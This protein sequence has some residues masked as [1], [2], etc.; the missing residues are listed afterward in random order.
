V[1]APHRLYQ[2]SGASVSLPHR[3]HAAC[4]LGKTAP[5]QRPVL[6][7]GRSDR[8]SHQ[9]VLDL[10]DRLGGVEALGTHIDTV[11]DRVVGTTPRC[12]RMSGFCKRGRPV[13]VDSGLMLISIADACRNVCL[14]EALSAAVGQNRTSADTTVIPPIEVLSTAP[15]SLL[16][17]DLH[18]DIFPPSSRIRGHSHAAAWRVRS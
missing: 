18:T 13:R 14:L 8:T 6:G 10:G 17:A 2:A 12:S 4:W 3:L 15:E 11:H 7:C 1:S 16:C 9:P 5:A